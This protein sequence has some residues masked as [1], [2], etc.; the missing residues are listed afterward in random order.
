MDLEELARELCC[1]ER[2]DNIG[3]APR[4]L[5][6]TQEGHVWTS[7]NRGRVIRTA[8]TAVRAY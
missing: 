1:M 2:Y 7:G 6:V 3:D 4:Y 5:R 8:F